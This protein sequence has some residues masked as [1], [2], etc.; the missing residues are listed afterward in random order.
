[1]CGPKNEVY[2][3]FARGIGRIE[4]RTFRITLLARSPVPI[5]AGGDILNG[6]IYFI[7][8]PRVYSYRVPG[9]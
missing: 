2:T 3:L 5:Q 1:V 7:S 9:S 4:P 8:G 6:F